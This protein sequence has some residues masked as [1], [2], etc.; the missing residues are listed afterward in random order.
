M[1][2]RDSNTQ[3][4]Y[5]NLWDHHYRTESDTGVCFAMPEGSKYEGYDFWVPINFVKCD[6]KLDDALYFSVPE[7]FIFRLKKQV[8]NDKGRYETVDETELDVEQLTEEFDKDIHEIA[9]KHNEARESKTFD[10]KKFQKKQEKLKSKKD[11]SSF[12]KEK[13]PSD[14]KEMPPEPEEDDFSF[15]RTDDDD[16]DS[17]DFEG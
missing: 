16:D 14:K 10:R 3:W 15:E 1:S 12:S 11:D 17:L 2:E 9:D 13:K 4:V 6:K 5:I 8:K 7:D